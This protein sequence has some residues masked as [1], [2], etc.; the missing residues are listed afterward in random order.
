MISRLLRKA[1][2][3]KVSPI[4]LCSSRANRLKAM[5]LI[6]DCHIVFI[7]GGDVEKGMI[8]L[9]EKDVAD[10]LR[11]QYRQG[12]PFFGV[13]A[14]S[15]MLARHWVR[16]DDSHANAS[17]ELFPCLGLA[18][19]YCDTHDEEDGWEELQAL[20]KLIPPGSISY[21]IPS[22]TALAAHPEGSV[23][24]I[25]GEVHRFICKGKRVV[26]IENL[27]P[28]QMANLSPS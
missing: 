19:V 5:R 4:P 27:A 8:V 6:E 11:D 13:S 9:E 25:G 21:G 22:G 16:W 20:T 24:A 7:S 23:Q 10:F 12:K 1:G 28:D 26:Q 18:Q 15:I 3:G 14:G 2:A 17:A